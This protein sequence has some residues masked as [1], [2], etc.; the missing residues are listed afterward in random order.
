MANAGRVAIVPKGDYSSST[1]YNRLDLVRYNEKAYV[2]KKG[3]TGVAPTN[4][5]YWMLITSDGITIDTA[6]SDTSTNPVQNKVVKTAIDNIQTT[7]A[8]TMQANGWYRIAYRDGNTQIYDNS[9]FIA[10]K[11]SSSRAES[12]LLRLEATNL[13][14]K[15]SII[16]SRVDD[17][18]QFHTM[19]KI[20][21]T[22]DSAK[23]YIEVYCSSAIST[24]GFA[25]T[26]FDVVNAQLTPWKGLN[27]EETSETLD[28]VTVTTTYDIPANASPVTDL[29]LDART[30]PQI[31]AV[32]T[33]LNDCTE[34]GIYFFTGNATQYANVPNSSANNG[35]MQVY[36]YSDVRI[37]QRYTSVTQGTTY[38]RV[39]GSNG[40]KDWTTL[41][42]T[43]DL[44]NYLPLSGGTVTKGSVLSFGKTDDSTLSGDLG[45]GFYGNAFE[46]WERGGEN[47]GAKLDLSKCAGGTGSEL[48]HT[49]NS[50]KVAIQSTAPTDTTSLWVD[51]ANKVTKAYIDGAWTQVA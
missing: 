41:A 19:K 8:R 34:N 14:A 50:A 9:C 2:A 1:A 32:G 45:I 17:A 4:T 40:W 33:N 10:L 22:Y 26:L 13:G 49:G 46:I 35:I 6:L 37:V 31:V 30:V 42:T 21:Y 18:V 27:F 24:Y 38:E 36:R 15:F 12:H 29:D 20:R 51:T 11:K 48:L 39:L 47:R 7:S 28:G 3:N 43:A 16:S 44:A 25:A 23:S 5:E